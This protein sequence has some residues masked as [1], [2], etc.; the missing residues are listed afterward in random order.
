MGR[1]ELPR[2]PDHTVGRLVLRPDN[3]PNNRP[4]NAGEKP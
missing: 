1:G 3:R 4:E 2:M